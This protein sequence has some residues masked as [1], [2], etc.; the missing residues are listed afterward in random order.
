MRALVLLP[1]AF[2]LELTIAPAWACSC[3]D[4]TDLESAENSGIA[5]V[6]EVV[7][8]GRVTA[9]G[10]ERNV[11][12]EVVEPILGVETGQRFLRTVLKDNGKNCGRDYEFKRG[13][14]WLFFGD[15]RWP[16]SGCSNDKLATEA[17][18]ADLVEQL[19]VDS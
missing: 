19:G 1:V 5:Y 10:S 3:D 8:V 16:I 2:S 18:V 4:P 13:E 14:R 9:C 12:V 6:G 17:N 7:G 15:D 11:R